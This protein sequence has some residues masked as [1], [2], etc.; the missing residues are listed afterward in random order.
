MQG[1][2]VDQTH[3]VLVSGKLVLQKR[4]EK[5]WVVLFRTKAPLQCLDSIFHS[6]SPVPQKEF[7]PPPICFW[8]W[9]FISWKCFFFVAIESIFGFVL[10][11]FV[12]IFQSFQR[13]KKIPWLLIQE[14]FDRN[15]MWQRDFLKTFMNTSSTSPL[16]NIWLTCLHNFLLT[17]KSNLAKNNYYLL[18]L[19]MLNS[20]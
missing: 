9:F 16:T 14:T 3:L 19:N 15:A 1:L 6:Q 11:C 12:C 8:E 17:A 4:I 10:F 20:F 13:C 5:P 2:I 7:E 18:Q